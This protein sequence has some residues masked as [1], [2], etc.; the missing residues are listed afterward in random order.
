MRHGLGL[1]FVSHFDHIF[2]FLLTDPSLAAPLVAGVIAD[3]LSTEQYSSDLPCW[4]KRPG[5]ESVVW[6]LVDNTNN[7]PVFGNNNATLVNYTSPVFAT[8][9]FDNEQLDVSTE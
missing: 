6:N 3:L 2:W 4:W 5:G 8:T 7:P 1:H 9:G